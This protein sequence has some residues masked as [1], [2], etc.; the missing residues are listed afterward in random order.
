MEAIETSNNNLEKDD[1]KLK[2]T[3]FEK[4]K[5]QLSDVKY[6]NVKEF[7]DSLSPSSVSNFK[8]VCSSFLNISSIVY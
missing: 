1:N 3:D 7:C 6:K 8:M 2:I 5:D 4:Q